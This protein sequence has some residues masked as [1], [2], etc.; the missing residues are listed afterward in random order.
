MGFD[1]T[2]KPRLEPE[3]FL[4]LQL[5]ADVKRARGSLLSFARRQNRR[6]LP[7]EVRASDFCQVTVMTP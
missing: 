1:K 5:D 7:K 2:L 4:S 3:I 6:I